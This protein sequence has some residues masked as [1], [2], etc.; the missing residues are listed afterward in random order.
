MADW[1]S[2]APRCLAT[3][4]QEERTSVITSEKQMLVLINLGKVIRP[5]P[6]SLKFTNLCWEGLVTNVE[7]L[8]Q[9]PNER[10]T[11]CALQASDS[12][13]RKKTKQVWLS[14]KGGSEKA[15]SLYKECG[16]MTYVCKV[17]KHSISP[18][19]PHISCQA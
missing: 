18:Q 2:G 13:I 12:T 3:S 11:S 8:K 5:S 7:S 10:A 17:S 16:S 9:L 14:W 6:N 15:I 1:C 19:T 4:C